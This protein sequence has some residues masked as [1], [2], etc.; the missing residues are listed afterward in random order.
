MSATQPLRDD[1]TILRAKLALLQAWLSSGA[2]E[3]P[4]IQRL[5]ASI[6]DHLYRH[7][8]REEA[9]LLRLVST[10]TEPMADAWSQ[11]LADHDRQR[12]IVTAL[13][14][15]FMKSQEE[16]TDQ[17]SCC[18]ANFVNG[19]LAQITDEEQR[20]FP[21]FD[22]AQGQ[23]STV[24]HASVTQA[25]ESSA[26]AE[27]DLPSVPVGPP[28][29]VIT[30]AMT[31]QDVVQTYPF[32]RRIFQ[33]FEIDPEGD[34]ACRLD[35][36]R[37]RRRVDLR[38]LVEALN[39]SLADAWPARLPELLWESCDG[40]MVL[41]ASR[42]I[43][44]MNPAL[45]RLTGWRSRDVLG[46]HECGW[47]FECEDASGCPLASHPERCPGTKAVRRLRPMTAVEYTIRTRGG[48]RV[49]V[50]ASYTPIQLHPRGPI[51]TM[52]I[53]R[54]V[55]AQHR[56]QRWM[57]RQTHQIPSPAR[58]AERR[59]QPRIVVKAPML[60]DTGGCSTSTSMPWKVTTID[61]SLA[62][63]SCWLGTGAPVDVGQELV[64]SIAILPPDQ[65]RVRYAQ[66]A[67]RG[68][69]VRIEHK[70]AWEAQPQGRV[71][72]IA[73]AEDVT[74]LQ[75]ASHN[76]Y[77]RDAETSPEPKGGGMTSD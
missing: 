32:T 61:V 27:S 50:N 36:L 21:R 53:M 16:S 31:V 9:L 41:D 29:S 33:L 6:A 17:L 12:R 14:E 28:R 77:V 59:R 24:S 25:S 56:R 7:T 46:R 38:A 5:S 66:L 22:H 10:S 54:D 44:A 1:H 20:L 19:L 69:I 42:C 55:S 30:T 49:M 8:Q 57:L 63:A 58:A 67:G 72:G 3:R 40:M 51:Y 76:G 52:A 45:E 2:C 68:R 13:L 37:W 73:F 26:Q 75:A 48:R 23:R 15:L 18:G 35:G 47:L 39:R 62:G 74:V 60:L 70:T 4:S 43:V 34:C 11:L 71:L 65:S 64:W